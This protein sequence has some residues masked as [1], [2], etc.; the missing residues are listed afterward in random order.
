MIRHDLGLSVFLRKFLNPQKKPF[1]EFFGLFAGLPHT[2]RDSV[3]PV[4]GTVFPRHI[5]I[6]YDIYRNVSYQYGY[7]T[8]F[9][10]ST[11]PYA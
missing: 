2:S 4:R 3:S 6:F 11:S 1:L 7:Y 5:E 8:F 10:F 9:A